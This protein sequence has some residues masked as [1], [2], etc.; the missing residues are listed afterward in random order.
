MPPVFLL[1]VTFVS[2]NRP[3]TNESLTSKVTPLAFDVLMVEL[4]MPQTAPPALM[5]LHVGPVKLL[6]PLVAM[7]AVMAHAGV[8][9]VELKFPLLCARAMPAAKATIKPTPEDPNP[10]LCIAFLLCRMSASAAIP[11]S[12]TPEETLSP[13]TP[14]SWSAEVRVPRTER[15]RWPTPGSRL[16]FD[17]FI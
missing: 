3:V 17:P 16:H 7:P 6:K 4:I 13:R 14:R 8:T 2:V 11:G 9:A 12:A 5:V 15:V 10:T 1:E